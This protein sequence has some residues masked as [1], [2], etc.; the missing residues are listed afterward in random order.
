MSSQRIGPR[1]E[2]DTMP[3]DVCAV[4]KRAGPAIFELFKNQTYDIFVCATCRDSNRDGWAPHL[5]DKV[6]ARLQAAN[7]P[8]PPR[9]P[10]ALLPLG[11]TLHYPRE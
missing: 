10:N 11:E 8:V 4:M 3:C 6:L 5:E 9:L 7:Q 1:D 2:T